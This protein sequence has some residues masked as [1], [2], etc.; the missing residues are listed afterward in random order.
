[1]KK[2]FFCLLVVHKS[3]HHHQKQNTLS[4]ITPNKKTPSIFIHPET[5]FPQ[6]W[7]MNCDKPWLPRRRSDRFVG[8]SEDPDNQK[9]MESTE[10][11]K[12]ID[13]VVPLPSNS[14]HQDDYYIFSMG[15]LSTFICHCYWEGAE[16]RDQLTS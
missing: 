3:I 8:R 15:S 1:M 16:I 2:T 13:W 12:P 6:V 7:W 11:M 9:L 4:K 10:T 5:P 14:H